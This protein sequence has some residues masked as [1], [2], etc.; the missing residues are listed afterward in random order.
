MGDRVGEARVGSV[1]VVC[2]CQEWG[3][4]RVSRGAK[5]WAP[6]CPLGMLEPSFA[7]TWHTYQEKVRNSRP[8]G[9]EVLRHNSGNMLQEWPEQQ[10]ARAPWG[11][12]QESPAVPEPPSDLMSSELKGLPLGQPHWSR[13]Y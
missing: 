8:R 4:A 1:C 6:G 7:L 3:L 13:L 5:P 10:V 9:E 12:L 11:W 2:V